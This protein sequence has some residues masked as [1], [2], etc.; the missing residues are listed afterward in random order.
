MH[1]RLSTPTCLQEEVLA[2]V[3][4]LLQPCQLH[5]VERVNKR[6]RN[7]G[8]ITMSFASFQVLCTKQILPGC[9]LVQSH[10]ES[11]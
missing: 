8:A 9:C 11:W 3:L 2:R 1:T 6:L 7:S 5:W 10:L 4:S